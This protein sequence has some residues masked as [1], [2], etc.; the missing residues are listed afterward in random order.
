MTTNTP[1]LRTFNAPAAQEIDQIMTFCKCLATAPFYQKMGA[2]GVLAIYLT[3][4]ELHL[5]LMACLN[6]GLY[7]FDGKVTMSGLLMHMMLINA[8]IEVDVKE[9]NNK[10][11]EIIF[12]RNVKGK[13]STFKYRYTIEDAAQAGYLGKDV[14]KKTPRDM[15]FNRTV[16]GG[17][18]K[19]A[20]DVLLG[21]YAFGEILE[22]D[23]NLD[24]LNLVNEVPDIAK[25][26]IVKPVE[27]I[28]NDQLNDLIDSMTKCTK[29][30]TN[31]LYDYI[32]KD[33]GV[34][35]MSDLPL[36]AY[37]K[38][39]LSMDKHI[40]ENISKIESLDVTEEE[41]EEAVDE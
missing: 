37:S 24:H 39:K 6:G 10:A 41:K 12:S 2:G 1:A 13:T 18:R 40:S 8:G 35:S 14:W 25:S 9:L 22:A 16:S 29:D 27:I 5:P 26:E 38:I 31:K 36:K 23:I 21:A 32:E 30:Y 34:D 7:T 11:C 20:P 19:F 33:L 15:L 17:A 28:N 3:A 4:K